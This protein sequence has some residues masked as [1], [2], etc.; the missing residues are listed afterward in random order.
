[1]WINASGSNSDATQI[2]FKLNWSQYVFHM[3]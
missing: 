3:V 2:N 1:M